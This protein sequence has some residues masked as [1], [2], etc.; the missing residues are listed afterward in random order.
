MN[1]NRKCRA[2]NHVVIVGLE[3]V[4]AFATALPAAA[5]DSLSA[6]IQK[7]PA[8]RSAKLLRLPTTRNFSFG[9]CL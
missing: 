3:L 7:G 6:R 1:R 5:Q 8:K 4:S 9:I 2:A